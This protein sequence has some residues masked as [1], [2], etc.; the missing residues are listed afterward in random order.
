MHGILSYRRINQ[1][2]RYL[3]KIVI[4]VLMSVCPEDLENGGLKML[5]NHTTTTLGA[6]LGLVVFFSFFL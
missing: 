6:S 1:C 3:Y 4:F 5:P 2:T